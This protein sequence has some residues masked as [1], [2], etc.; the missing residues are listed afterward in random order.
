MMSALELSIWAKVAR[1][2]WW[3]V[4]VWQRNGG[5]AIE[6]LS[7]SGCEKWKGGVIFQLRSWAE[8]YGD[9]RCGLLD[10]TCDLSKAKV[11]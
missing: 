6:A 5:G 8:M 4:E 2:P 9:E 7:G 3:R 10:A 1:R 11:N